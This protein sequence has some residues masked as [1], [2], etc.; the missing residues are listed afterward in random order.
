[1]YKSGKTRRSAFPTQCLGNKT[2]ER[3][4][5]FMKGNKAM[6]KKFFVG[7][8]WVVVLVAVFFAG[9]WSVRSWAKSSFDSSVSEYKRRV[10]RDSAWA[11]FN[12]AQS[13][14]G[15]AEY[16]AYKNRLYKLEIEYQ[17]RYSSALVF[18]LDP[19]PI[20]DREID[21]FE[22]VLDDI[23][24]QLDNQKIPR[25]EVWELWESQHNIASI[26]WPFVVEGFPNPDGSVCEVTYKE[27]LDLK[28]QFSPA[29]ERMDAILA[30]YASNMD[31]ILAKYVKN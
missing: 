2:K 14:L 29:K 20:M 6:F 18:V 13:K 7:A 5:A 11:A 17:H 8:V 19:T 23:A 31:A 9:R 12:L 24:M 21:S 10:D 15:Q 22:D 4:M 1:M 16:E 27:Y 30:K 28:K 26:H 3:I 25:K